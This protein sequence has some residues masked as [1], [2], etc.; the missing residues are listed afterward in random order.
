MTK[1]SIIQASG[2][3]AGARP[4][5]YSQALR[6]FV[7]NQRSDCTK[8]AYWS[9]V[10]GFG[11]WA[12]KAVEAITIGDLVD[13]RGYLEAE[14]LK[15]STIAQKLSRLRQ[16]FRFLR[17]HGIIDRD[18]TAGVKAPKVVDETNKQVLSLG[19]ARRLLQSI[20]TTNILGKR[21]KAIIAL[22]LVCGLREVEITR[23]QAGDLRTVDDVAVLTVRGKGG[24]LADVPLRE[25]VK[26][27]IDAYLQER[28]TA[29][30]QGNNKS[31]DAVF[32]GH[33]GRA[34]VTMTTRNIRAMLD[35][36]LRSLGLKQAGVSG[37]SLRHT[38]VTQCALAGADILQLQDF[39]RHSDPKTTVRYVHRLN[40]LRDHAV[41]LN[42]IRI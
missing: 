7:D 16:F 8:R 26:G 19:N 34:G 21:D 2:E 11:R 17:D 25:D 42:P 36:R 1:T 40:R 6:A 22:M 15:A 30:T 10:K 14:G 37:H 35:R 28:R 32:V 27:L 41:H 33:N 23:A 39:A 24:K 4:E 5:A 38:A 12:G 29:E 20:D 18:P 31:T 13:Y 3:L 9:A